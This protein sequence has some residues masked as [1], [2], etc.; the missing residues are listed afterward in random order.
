MESDG[1]APEVLLWRITADGGA[2]GRQVVRNMA[3]GRCW[4][5]S[6]GSE[7]EKEVVVVV[8]IWVFGVEVVLVVVVVLMVATDRIQRLRHKRKIDRNTWEKSG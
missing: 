7:N 5:T 1:D 8:V 6:E 4:E 3:M 2:D